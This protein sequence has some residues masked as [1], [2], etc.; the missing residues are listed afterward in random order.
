MD[1]VPATMIRRYP[2]ESSR[3]SSGVFIITRIG[4][5]YCRNTSV[6]AATNAEHSTTDAQNDLRTPEASFAPNL[7]P[8]MIVS[9][10][11]SPQKNPSSMK[12][13]DPA[14]PTA[15]SLFGPHQRPTIME[16]T[17]L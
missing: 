16:S 6:T 2:R 8:V 12:I 15:A 11:G 5:R 7:C 3:I 13:T 10:A 4:L 9:P 14:L 1:G 17:M